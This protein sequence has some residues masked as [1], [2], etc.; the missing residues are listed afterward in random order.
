MGKTDINEN[1]RRII[2][3]Y[4]AEL[5]KLPPAPKYLTIYRKDGTIHRVIPNKMWSPFVHHWTRIV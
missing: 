2:D 3:K 1:D 5:T 4:K